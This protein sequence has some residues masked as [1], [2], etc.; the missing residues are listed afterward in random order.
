MDISVIPNIKHT[1]ADNFFLLAGPCAIESEAMAMQ[2][3]EQILKIS[4]TYQVPFIFKGSFKKANRSRI[5]S[6]TG[7][8]DKKALEIL[9][10]VGETFNIPTVTDIHQVQDATMAANYVDV[11]QIPAF[12]VRQTD[13]VVAAAQTGKVVNLKKGQFMSPESMQ[14]AVQKVL[15]SN[16]ELVMV[17]DRGTMFGYQDLIVDFRGI[18][19]M[20]EFATTV[21]DV[22]HSL[23]QPNQSSGVTGGR[24]DMIETIARAGIVN[25]VDGLFIETHYNPSEAKSDG[26]NMLDLKHLEQLIKRLT[27]I[28]VTI[29]QF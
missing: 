14:H 6:F 26:A 22:T 25:H 1:Q 12:L 4:D 3:A 9:K 13:L 10:K 27:Q 19:S 5:D 8:G 24:P 29:N 16:N 17:T 2:I 20:R 7:I 23:Q 15:D 28:R 18:P 11:L 21:L